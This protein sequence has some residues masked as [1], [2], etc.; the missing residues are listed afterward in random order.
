MPLCVR[1]S[2]LTIVAPLFLLGPAFSQRPSPG[3]PPAVPNL[4]QLVHSSGYIFAGTVTAVERV[5]PAFRSEVAT[6]RVTFR[7]EQAV[8]GV[9]D[10]QM[11]VIHEWAGL[12]ES[13]ERYRPG[14]RVLLFL[15]RPSRLGLTS[16]VGG[17][18]GRFNVDRSG[19]MILQS[20]AL[21]LR[22]SP[23]ATGLRPGKTGISVRSLTRAIHS[24]GRK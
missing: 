6:V 15:Y 2:L 10:G 21:P 1:R 16:P 13:G 8:R 14:E 20:T 11:L 7:V 18:M 9:R 4:G 3:T 5:A 22:P 12:W 24:M 23:T 19:R 17:P